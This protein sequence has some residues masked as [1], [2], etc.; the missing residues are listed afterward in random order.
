[1][2]ALMNPLVVLLAALASL[3]FATG[4]VRAALVMIAMIALGVSLRFYQ[5]ARADTAAEKLRAMIQLTA[6]VLRDGEPREESL[7]SIVPGDV[8][9]LAAGD[10]IPAD[11]RILACRDLFLSQAT[12]TG[13]SLPV[14]KSSEVAGNGCE[15]LEFP[16]LCFL[17]TSV[18]SGS[19]TALVS[20]S[21]S[22]VSV[23][24]NCA[25]RPEASPRSCSA[26]LPTDT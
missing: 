8:I 10:M 20:R 23:W 18:E 9:L 19:A 11:V 13:E 26:A 2:R 3:S 1:M 7:E 24:P 14:E 6:S 16:N 5:E 4:D 25:R 21:T 15:P 22:R 17:G 12:L